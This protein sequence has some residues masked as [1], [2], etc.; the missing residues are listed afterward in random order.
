MEL[1]CLPLDLR[2]RHP[3]R[4]ARHTYPS[5]PILVVALCHEGICGFGE[6]TYN[7]YY[8]TDVPSLK[9]LME[10]IAGR[11]KEYTF[12]DPGHLADFL[13]QDLVGQPFAGAALNNA[14]WDLWG[15]IH[16]KTTAM[17]AGIQGE[18]EVPTSYTLGIDEPA[19][20]VARMRELPWPIYKIKLGTANDLEIVRTLRQETDARLRVDA[21]GAW[22]TLQALRYAEELALLGVEFIEQ[23]LPADDWKGMAVVREESALPVIADESCLNEHNIPRCSAHFHGINIK[24]LKCGGL[25][26]A[27]R[28]VEKAREF[29]LKV[30]VGCMTES[31]IGISAAAQLL[32]L[33]DYADLDGPLLLAEDLADGLEYRNGSIIRGGGPGLGFTLKKEV[34]V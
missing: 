27:L 28:M 9:R 14:A 13:E 17:L 1:R 23:P 7:P 32:P 20:M 29:G 15:K 26:A 19:V 4:I 31:T 10:N 11:L 30:M 33:V 18:A 5:Q 22:S 6:A 2:L 12:R 3:F 16:N 21:N 8:G 34:S 25:S 24:L